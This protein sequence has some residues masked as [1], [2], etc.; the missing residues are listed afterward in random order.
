MKFSKFSEQVS[1]KNIFFLF[2]GSR[3]NN[4]P[5]TGSSAGLDKLA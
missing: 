3:A 5:R 2:Q 4:I 1:I